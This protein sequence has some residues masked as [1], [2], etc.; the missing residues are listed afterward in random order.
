MSGRSLRIQVGMLVLAPVLAGCSLLFAA[1]PIDGPV[2]VPSPVVVGASPVAL[3][4]AA[5]ATQPPVTATQGP[6]PSSAELATLLGPE[7]FAAVGVEGAGPAS[8][9]DAGPGAVLSLIHI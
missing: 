1:P 2:P 9:T 4:T 3:P 6:P 8:F 5:A 7:D